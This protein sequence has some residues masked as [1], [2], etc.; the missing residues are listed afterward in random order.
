[1]DR[2]VSTTWK[3]SGQ[4]GLDLSPAK[5]L[6]LCLS[7]LCWH[8]EINRHGRSAGACMCMSVCVHAGEDGE[9]H[10]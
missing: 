8:N 7:L 3:R 9:H 10:W 4:T 2:C 1:M 6:V 5:I